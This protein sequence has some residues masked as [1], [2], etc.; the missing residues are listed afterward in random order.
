MSRMK[1]DTIASCDAYGIVKFWN[2]ATSSIRLSVDVGP[3]PANKVAFDP[4]G[5]I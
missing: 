4:T 5:K 2:I 1:G 3:H